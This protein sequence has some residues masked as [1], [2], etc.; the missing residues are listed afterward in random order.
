MGPY[1]RCGPIHSSWYVVTGSLLA[2]QTFV[3]PNGIYFYLFII[4]TNIIIYFMAA[5][6]ANGSSQAR[7]WVPATAMATPDPSAT[8]L[9]WGSNTH[10]WINP[11]HGSQI[12]HLVHQHWELWEEPYY[13]FILTLKEFKFTVLEL[14]H[15]PKICLYISHTVLLMYKA[16]FIHTRYFY[17][18]AMN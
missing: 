17:F 9:G 13:S 14:N 2:T 16:G 6:E 8:V 18:I 7:D 10:L 5:L 4:V 1:F 3:L 15:K 12:P 11:S